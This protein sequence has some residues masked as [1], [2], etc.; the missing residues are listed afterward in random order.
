MPIFEYRCETCGEEFEEIL[1]SENRDR[2][3]TC[4]KC[5]SKRS[6]RLMSAFAGG[7]S[8]GSCSTP[9]PT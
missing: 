8:C 9:K 7:A 6:K 3:Q 5:G 1:S 2:P 4:P